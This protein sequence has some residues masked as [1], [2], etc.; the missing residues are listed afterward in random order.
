MALTYTPI[1]ELEAVN[2]MLATIGET[3]V[4]TIPASGISD[5]S[6]ARSELHRTNREVQ[7]LAL[8]FNTD[9]KIRF[10]PDGEGKIN[11]PTNALKVIS[12]YDG[13]SAS[14]DYAVRGRYLWDRYNQTY[15]FTASVL[16]NITYFLEWELMPEHVRHYVTVK[17]GRSFQANAVGSPQLNAFTQEDE[18]R[19]RNEMFRWEMNKRGGSM[20]QSPS[21]YDIFNRRA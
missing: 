10:S 4:S 12:Y 13:Y 11:I 19:A 20:L 14:Y 15:V 18:V 3:P 17:A 21:T 1:T 2:A 16:L 7:G 8:K 6:E 9:Y 5:A